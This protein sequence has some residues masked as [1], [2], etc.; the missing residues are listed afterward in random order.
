M[1]PKDH[2]RAA[3]QLLSG[4]VP[5]RTV[6]EH[7]GWREVGDTWHYL[8]AGGAIGKDGLAAGVD[9]VPPAP[10]AGFDL[11]AP[12][13]GD[14]LTAA[15]RASLGMLD[16][17]A[18]DR[19][20]V[21]LYAAIWRAVIGDTD[22]GVHLAGP[23]GVFKTELAALAQ[24]H[25]G[26]GLDSRHLPGSWSSTA[27]S[28]EG[29]AF[30]AKD[31]VLVVDDFAPGGSVHDVQRCHRE[32]DRLLRAQGN[33]SG[34]GRMRADGTLRPPRPPRGMVLSTGEDV[35]RG[36]SLRARLLIV[37]VSGG[38]VD[39][40]LLTACQEDAASGLYAQAL[41]G[42]IRWLAPKYTNIR[43][44]LRE[45]VSGMREK[46]RIDDQQHARTPGIAADLAIGLRWFLKF[47]RAI[48]AISKEEQAELWKRCQQA[49]S[50]VAR[51]QADHHAAV[52]PAGHFLRLLR[53]ALASERAHVV[54][55]FG[56]EPENAAAWG[57]RASEYYTGRDADDTCEQTRWQPQG[58]KVGWLDGKD[59]YL[60]PEASFAAAQELAR[61]Q[62]ESLTV[63]PRTLHKRLKERG[64]LASWD[65]GRQRNTIR[66]TLEGVKDREVL[67]LR[68]DALSGGKE[69]SEP[70]ADR[71][72]HSN[73]KEFRADGRGKDQKKPSG[74]TVRDAG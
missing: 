1:G 21:P 66:R 55:P 16:G 14:Q 19:I 62:G 32:A 23:T 67:H 31:A 39:V 60:E 13:Q 24:Q 5:R 71:G 10:L 22:F 11:P 48:R 8:H 26:A 34:R 51:S 59:L 15:V 33:R 65:A 3:L 52:E 37:E 74:K 64:L 25:W 69:P 43:S 56:K 45:E 70:S 27:N 50:E 46:L 30:A 42:F 7:L 41:A 18:P 17:L 49:L 9:V 38:D 36:Q 2:L 44:H 61:D 68:A 4:D 57:W 6:Y 53:G 54:G 63:T 28:L 72:T 58:R 73:N 47:A 12:P 40:E 29:I 35:P 20:I